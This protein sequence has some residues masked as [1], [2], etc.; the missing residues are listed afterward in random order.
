[1]RY[2]FFVLLF[3]PLLLAA[4]PFW[5]QFTEV[6]HRFYSS[7]GQPAMLR[8]ANLTPD[9]G[10]S[11][12]IDAKYD[13]FHA[14][15]ES[16]K[17]EPF[18]VERPLN[19]FFTPAEAD[20]QLFRLRA[21]I[22]TNQKYGYTLAVERD[23]VAVETLK[24]K[25]NIYLFFASLAATWT[26]LDAEGL[27]TMLEH[28][29]EL[30]ARIPVAAFVQHTSAAGGET[31]EIAD[32]L[33]S[34]LAELQTLA[35]FYADFLEY[36]HLNP[37]LLHYET[38]IQRLQLGSLIARINDNGFAAECNAVLRYVKLDLGRVTLFALTLLTAWLV[39]LFI[40]KRVYAFLKALILY[41]EDEHDD[42]MLANI[43]HIRKPFSVLIIT[44]GLELALEILTYPSTLERGSLFFYF[45]Y[46]VTISYILV[47]LIDNFV[48]QYL[49]RRAEVTNK[50]IR[51]E[52]VNLILSILKALIFIT[53]GLLLLVRAGIDI[54]GILASLGIGGL[55]VA[56]AAKET[57][58]NFFGLLKIIADNSFSQG[59]WIQA[60][61]VEGTVV[62]IG[63]VSTDVRTFD[64]ALITVPNATLA[65]AALKNWN[66]RT[67]GRRLKLHIGVTYG[68]RPEELKNAVDA[69][70]TML[71]EHPGIAAPEKYDSH[72]YRSRYKQERKLVS[73][74]DKHGIKTT[75]MVYLDQLSASSMDI[76]VYAFSNTVNWQ[77]WLELKQDVIFRIWEILEAHNLSFA[78][79]SQSLYF[80]KTN[81]EESLGTLTPKPPE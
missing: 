30:L 77:E 81:L 28:E 64:N 50:E 6:E 18:T 29:E 79:P 25:Q 3:A 53:A 56:L 76:L 26:T 34:N 67:V 66:R 47:I 40:Y 35:A 63:F 51:S 49:L 21:R 61:D 10:T 55:A 43:E 68:S 74:E 42:M 39:S 2:L 72:S 52:L 71:Y 48:F 5:Q 22:G 33:R 19:D 36:L 27:E 45:V 59:D 80:D 44:F 62:E 78:F 46:L 70:R 57:L 24:L 7:S 60:G 31:S 41:K 4:D 11:E 38:L 8:D 15:V 75:L 69:I 12:L 1:M 17:R 23:R 16:L 32:E 54:T 20:K 65:N 73:F 58:S 9:S 14:L 13:A 37:T